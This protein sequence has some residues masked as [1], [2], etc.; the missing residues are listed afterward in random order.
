MKKYIVKPDM[1]YTKR[2]KFYKIICGAY[3]PGVCDHDAMQAASQIDTDPEFLVRFL[4]GYGAWNEEELKDHK[5]NLARLCWLA[6]ADIQER[7]EFWFCH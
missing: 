4:K 5:Q 1:L 6:C 7:K 3:H 2:H